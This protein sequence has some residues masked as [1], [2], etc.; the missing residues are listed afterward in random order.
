MQK[1]TIARL[2]AQEKDLHAARHY[3][4]AKVSVLT[5]EGQE[6]MKKVGHRASPTAMGAP[7]PPC[8]PL[9]CQSACVLQL[10]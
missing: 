6:L 5:A 3:A 10:A 1:E 7:C 2:Q 4:E 8:L 9:H